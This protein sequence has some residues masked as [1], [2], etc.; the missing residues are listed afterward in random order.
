MWV[1]W[2]FDRLAAVSLPMAFA[3]TVLRAVIVLAVS[4]ALAELSWR[5]IEGPSLQLKPAFGE[6]AVV[7]S[8]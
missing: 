5:Y 3:P 8:A 6:P 1:F 2:S 7:K 4:T